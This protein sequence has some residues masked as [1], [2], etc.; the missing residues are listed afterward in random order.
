MVGQSITATAA[1]AAAAGGEREARQAGPEV[2]VDYE[3]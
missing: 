1:T 3:G 2:P